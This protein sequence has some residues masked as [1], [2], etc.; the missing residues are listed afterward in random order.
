[1]LIE[2][3]KHA[4]WTLLE[5]KKPLE[6]TDTLYRFQ[7]SL[8][9]HQ[10]SK[11]TVREEHTEAQQLVILPMDVGA[12][13]TY[14]KAGEIPKDVRDALVKAAQLKGALVDAQRQLQ[15]RQ[16]KLAE[17]TTE[18]AR[19]RENMKAVSP[20]TD[21]YKR[22]LAELDQQETQIQDLHKQVQALQKDLEQQQKNLEAYLGGLTV[23]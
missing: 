18:Q 15:E 16:Q 3:P 1:L 2:A 8:A 10:P 11:V 13:Q 6:T 19:I 5:P 17:I 7:G 14:M 9:P 21:Y 4:G 22:L 23:G 20:G 12:V